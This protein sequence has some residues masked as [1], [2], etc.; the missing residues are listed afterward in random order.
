MEWDHDN[1]LQ[2]QGREN[3]QTGAPQVSSLV[4]KRMSRQGLGINK[5]AGFQLGE[6]GWTSIRNQREALG[7]CIL[8]TP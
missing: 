7:K 5:A 6:S 1:D 2:L 3:R 4:A 8:C